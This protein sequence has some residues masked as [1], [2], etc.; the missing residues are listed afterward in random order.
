MKPKSYE[1]ISSKGVIQKF[2]IVGLKQGLMLDE[3]I[4]HIEFVRELAASRNPRELKKR[5]IKALTCIGFS[6]FAFMRYPLNQTS[7]FFLNSLP[8]ELLVFYQEQKFYEHDMAVDYLKAG[9]TEDLYFSQ[10]QKT[11]ES[12]SFLTHT[13]TQ[14]LRILALY[15][16]F[17]FNDAYL[18]P[19]RTQ[20]EHR[21]NKESLLLA[22]MA[23]GSTQKEFMMLIE[24]SGEALRL[25]GDTALRIHQAKF[26]NHNPQV[27]T[28]PK[29]IQLLTA[30]AKFDLTISQAAERLFISPHTANKHVAS[31]KRIFGARTQ[32]N[33]IYKALEQGVIDF[34]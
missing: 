30:M 22:V 7:N 34:N 19:I 20:R 14:N 9:N 26:T 28:N 21:S 16:K 17:E 33:L 3:L 29:P 13:F 5:L 2:D 27:P 8:K 18:I 31:A 15:K 6:D 11:I 25:L 24:N 32:A 10:I 4:S 23:K 1:T 12:S